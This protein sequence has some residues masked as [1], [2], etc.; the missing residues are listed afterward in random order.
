VASGNLQ[1]LIGGLLMIGFDGETVGPDLEALMLEVRPGGIILFKR[2]V[3]G[4]PVQVA[5]LIADL[6][7]L[8]QNHFGRPLLTAIDQEGGSVKRLAPPFLQ[9]PS[10]R[11]MA[12]TMS[13]SDVRALAKQSGRELHA[14]G[15]NLNLTP[16]LD[17]NTDPDASYMTDR[18]FGPDPEIAAQYADALIRGHAEAAVLTCAK[19]FPGIGDVRIDPHHDLPRVDHPAER[20]HRL[21]MEPFRRAMESGVSA[22]MT[23]H[24]VYPGLDPDAPATFSPKITA[25][26]IR[27]DL[28][29]TGMVLTDDLEMGA[30]VKHYQI[31]PAALE[32]VKAGADML[33]VCHKP[34]RIREAVQALTRG[35]ESGQIN[36]ARLEASQQRLHAV[37]NRISPPPLGALKEVFNLDGNPATHVSV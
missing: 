27:R 31:G 5:Q 13:I 26:L 35:M 24:I 25:D 6:Q 32:S 37:L 9:A 20:I 8:A 18:S 21:E 3:G 36:L 29:F 14:V 10:Q 33:L 7:N 19:H 34:E 16:V 1:D 15:L 23:S 4:G 30:I 28:G 22:I 2:N 11:H 17:L 12:D